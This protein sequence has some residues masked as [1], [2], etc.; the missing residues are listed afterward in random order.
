M[1]I[2][3]RVGAKC[4]QWTVLNYSHKND[5]YQKFWLCKCSCGHES[6][7][8]QSRLANGRSTC[9]KDCAN[10]RRRLHPPILIGAK[11]GKWLVLCPDPENK[12][13]VFAKCECKKTHRINKQS[14][15]YGESTQC[16]SCAGKL[17]AT[18]HGHNCK[19]KTSPE[20]RAWRN[21]KNRVCNTNFKGYARYGGRGIKMCTRWLNSFEYFL[22]DVGIKPSPNHSLER[23]NND[24]NYEPN[25][26]KW[27][28]P[29][30]QN[31]NRGLS[32]KL[33]GQ[34]I[35]I[36]KLAT[37]L[38][39][40]PRTIKNLIY[41]ADFCLNEIRD[42]SN[43]TH[44]QKIEM[45][46]SIKNNAPLTFT[47]LTKVK[48]PVLPSPKRHPLWCTWHSMK[49]RCNNPKNKDY[50]NY[51]GRGI[52]VCTE[53][54]TFDDFL[55]SILNSIGHKQSPIHQLDRID[56]NKNYEPNNVRWATKQ[57][58]AR[59]KNTTIFLNG[60]GISAEELSARYN[61]YRRTVIKLIRLGW[62]EEG[63]AFFSKLSFKEK[64]YLKIV[65]NELTQK[66]AI[67]MYSKINN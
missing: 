10:A 11:Y 39:I 48:S 15:I 8:E 46:K 14:L 17:T 49:Q 47:E 50:K 6:I 25:N 24:G 45:G 2:D 61:I 54:Q 36:K 12:H 59:N 23:I 43:M 66:E 21:A 18:K 4:G 37:E 1:K 52:K 60:A 53:W 7:L 29:I 35:D 31:H 33:D 57:Q 38:N 62:N 64:K 19:G 5:H 65:A 13:Y 28:L 30:E 3:I 27:A 22:Q 58:Q 67:I 44:Y 32:T 26:V 56:N 40:H 41:K 63:L 55:K 20:Y 16:H 9:C 34:Y 51:G 42:F